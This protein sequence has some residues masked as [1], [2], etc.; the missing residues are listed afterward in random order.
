MELVYYLLAGCLSG[1]LAGLLGIGGGLITVP[2]MVII[3]G[4]LEF[5]PSRVMHIAIATSLAAI[6]PTSII[7]AYKHQR[8]N[9]IH[10]DYA[11]LLLPG[12]ILGS[13]LGV[14]LV[15][16]ISREPLQIIFACFL[17]LVSFYMFF[18]QP[19]PNK[20]FSGGKLLA[21]VVSTHIGAI[22]SLLGVGGGTMTVPFLVW[23]GLNPRIA[24]G[25]SAFCGI[26]IAVTAVLSF[27][28]LTNFNQLSAAGGFV[29]WPA[30]ISIVAA[31]LF[32]TPL[33][34]NLAHKISTNKLKRF[35]S[36]L[37]LFVAIELLLSIN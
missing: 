31:S 2:A 33:G 5:D 14:F 23:R 13:I 17:L 1:F 15:V 11:R 3:L 32:F 35:F 21:R 18:G 28:F 22:S 6:I 10:W 9:A 16:Y 29:H 30:V 7:S 36:I 4:H 19:L 34:V 26:P 27:Y 12:L 20:S 8:H 37:L 24:V 25:T